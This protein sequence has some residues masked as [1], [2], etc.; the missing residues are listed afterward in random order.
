M[1]TDRETGGMEKKDGYAEGGMDG[2][3]GWGRD[4][5]R[6]G[7][8]N[9]T[10]GSCLARAGGSGEVGNTGFPLCF[11]RRIDTTGRMN[12]DSSTAP[13][14]ADCSLLDEE[15]EGAVAGWLDGWT[16]GW[17]GDTLGRGRS[18]TR[19]RRVQGPGPPD[20]SPSWSQPP[21]MLSWPA[22]GTAKWF[23]SCPLSP[24]LNS[25]ELSSIAQSLTLGS[26]SGSLFTDIEL[27]SSQ[28]NLRMCRVYMQE[29]V[30]LQMVHV[31]T[32]TSPAG[33]ARMPSCSLK[34]EL[35]WSCRMCGE[36]N[37][38]LHSGHMKI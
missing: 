31:G 12:L 23:C 15:E 21:N 20:R 17:L 4:G 38:L 33:L 34:W 5:R 9:V 27:T 32:L 10:D 13:Q 2:C 18:L 19:S 11:S 6:D 3:G 30:L 1:E 36:G 24:F 25:C 29:K 28:W 7:R 35:R 22:L 37:T 14:L 16:D 8:R 26:A